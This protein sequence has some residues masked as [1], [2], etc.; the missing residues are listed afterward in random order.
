M[1]QN[2]MAATTRVCL[3]PDPRCVTRVSATS[4]T[5]TTASAGQ[6]ALASARRTGRTV[7]GGSGVPGHR[8]TSGCC[9]V[10]RY[11]LRFHP[12]GVYGAAPA[13]RLSLAC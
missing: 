12:S 3:V 4:A 8:L 5:A 6:A 2:G 10:Y 7:R 9:P 1:F 13:V 11:A